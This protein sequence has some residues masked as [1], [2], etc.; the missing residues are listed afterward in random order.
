MIV[1]ERLDVATKQHIEQLSSTFKTVEPFNDQYTNTE[2]EDA[3]LYPAC[4]FE[5]M[6]PVNWKQYL[7]NWQSAT[8][9]MRFHVVVFDIK[10]TKTDLHSASQL[11]FQLTQNATIPELDGSQLTGEFMRVASTVPK[12]YK[13][14]KVITM[15]FEFELYDKSAIPNFQQVS[16]TAFTVET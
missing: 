4:Y 6:E 14:L 1:Y 3:K 10:R 5:L 15:D 9:R 11:L 16:N 12:R 2:N 13:Q 8:V 7:N